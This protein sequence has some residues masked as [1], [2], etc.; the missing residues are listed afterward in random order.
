MITGVL[1]QPLLLVL[2]LRDGEFGRIRELRPVV[3]CLRTGQM[4]GLLVEPL[5]VRWPE[6][7]LVNMR[8]VYLNLL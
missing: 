5:Q 3:L 2:W 4:L 8:P 7:T 6:D 1:R